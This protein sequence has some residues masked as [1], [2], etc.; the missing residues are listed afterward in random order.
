[1]TDV[2][3]INDD[4]R[5]II[6]SESYADLIINTTS[7]RGIIGI[8][9]AVYQEMNIVYSIAYLPVEQFFGD[10]INRFGYS[11]IPKLYGLASE[12]ALEA[13]R[14]DELRQTK[15]F[16]L[17]GSGVMIAVID[18]G[19]NYTLPAFRKADGTTKIEAI[20]DQ[21][22]QSGETPNDYGFGTEYKREQINLAL[23]AENPLQVVPTTDDNGHGT[24]V[25]AVAA[26][27]P[28]DEADFSG[29]APEA[30][31]IIVKL[32][33]AKQYLREFYEVR[34]GAVCYQENSIMW[35]LQYCR[36]VA[37]RLSRPVVFCL[38]IATSQNSH[39]GLSPLGTIVNFFSRTPRIGMV[40]VAGNEG[41]K[42]RH[43]FGVIDPAIGNIPVELSVDEGVGGFSMQLWGAS[44][45][46]FSIDIL[47]P[48]GEY[49]PRIAAGLRVSREITFIFD[50]T[51]INV[52]Y[53]TVEKQTG[54]QLIFLRFQNVSAG[55]WKFN[56]YGYGNL[57][58][59]FHI[60]LPMGDM[61][62]NGVRFIQPDIYTTVL[63]PGTTENSIM[64][65]AY[66][67]VNQTLYIEASRGY[68]RTNFIKPEFAAPGV[69]YIA[70]NQ[71][72]EYVPYSGTGVAAAHTA[73]IVALMMEWGVV[74]GN[75]PAISTLEIKNYLIRGAKRS[76]I[77][78]YPNRDWGYGILDLYNTF[79]ILRTRV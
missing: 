36:L 23:Q 28:E 65:T 51:I 78:T 61:I 24:M 69:D 2:V 25:A 55:I 66:Q 38:A 12:V 56:V 70:P 63:S 34:E 74:L 11:S 39:D 9:D 20:W 40:T 77:Q 43:F 16:N 44:P 1:M 32:M 31:L 68:T 48:S 73:G 67:P 27:S 22:I 46:L 59:N 17:F 7:P 47:S 21:T 4:Q 53:E 41:N 18:T 29:V 79:N 71:L 5:S 3:Y 19:I 13:S 35:A 60:W 76:R 54:D 58:N 26:G 37:F 57:T 6:T 33:P 52:Y 62:S 10:P 15:R 42:G 45:G 14:I 49:I 75:Q 72:G 64:V 8:P 30:E 50:E